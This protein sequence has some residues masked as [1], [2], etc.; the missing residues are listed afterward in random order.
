M[1]SIFDEEFKQYPDESEPLWSFDKFD[2]V[3]CLMVVLWA[4][5]ML[6]K[7]I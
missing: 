5:A 2:A 1:K 7:F 3:L 6:I 4:L